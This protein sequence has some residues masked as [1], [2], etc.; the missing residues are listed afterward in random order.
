MDTWFVRV[1]T[2]NNAPVARSIPPLFA[3]QAQLMSADLASFWTDADNDELFYT[4]TGLPYGTG[5]EFNRHTGVLE[6]TP[7]F[8]DVTGFSTPAFPPYSVLV[9]CPNHPP[10][11]P[12]PPKPQKNQHTTTPL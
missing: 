8:D 3:T 5:L 1:Y 12:P 4:L 7:T 10:T 6:G 11:S 9:L 2:A